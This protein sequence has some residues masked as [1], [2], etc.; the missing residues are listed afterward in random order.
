MQNEI[1]KIKDRI[2]NRITLIFGTFLSIALTASISR[3]FAIGWNSIYLLH[4]II[5]LSLVT[6][7]IRRKKIA[8]LFKLHLIS[9]ILLVISIAGLFVYAHYSAWFFALIA[10]A[11]VAILGSRKVAFIY[12]G[13]FLLF[14]FIFAIGTLLIIFI[15]KPT[16]MNIQIHL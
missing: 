13:V 2:V 1:N 9:I 6:V 10:I 5:F 8:T 14:Y 11:L 12:L 4:F 16:S 7:I 15:P 3:W